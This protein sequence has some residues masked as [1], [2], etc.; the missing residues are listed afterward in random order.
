ME[1]EMN[2][3][4][5]LIVFGLRVYRWLISP[6]KTFLVGPL[7]GCRFTPSCSAYALESVVRHGALMGG[8][9]ALRRVCR[10]HPWG[11]CGYD[12]VPERSHTCR[13]HPFRN[14]DPRALSSVSAKGEAYMS[15]KFEAQQ[16]KVPF[17]A[18][19]GN[20]SR[21]ADAYPQPSL[22]RNS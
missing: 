17:Y 20:R 2:A 10:C 13:L 21:A 15:V 6:A 4:Q 18:A 19:R 9:L 22:R 1:L 3:A 14:S 8:R 11:G 5:H 7:G 16:A 12:P